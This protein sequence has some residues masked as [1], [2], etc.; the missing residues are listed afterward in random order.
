MLSILGLKRTM[1][2][3]EEMFPDLCVFFVPVAIARVCA[4]VVEQTTRLAS[5]AIGGDCRSD[6]GNAPK[7]LCKKCWMAE[8]LLPSESR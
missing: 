4:Y 7:R 6:L 1:C 8:L 2:C 3:A 5:L